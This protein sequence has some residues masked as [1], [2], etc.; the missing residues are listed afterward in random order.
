MVKGQGH[1]GQ[2]MRCALPSPP[3]ATK[4]SVLLHDVILQ[5]ARYNALSLGGLCAVY[6]WK[7]VFVMATLRSRCGHYIFILW[8]L[9]SFFFLFFL[10]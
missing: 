3:A 10:A 2:K 5:Q 8:F 6:V 7:N 1:Q 4:L 9:L